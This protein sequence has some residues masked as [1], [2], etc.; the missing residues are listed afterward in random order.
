ME[1]YKF[2]L[3]IIG[4]YLASSLD[5]RMIQQYNVISFHCVYRFAIIEIKHRERG[6]YYAVCEI[7]FDD[8]K[9][10]EPFAHEIRTYNT[11]QRAEILYTA[12]TAL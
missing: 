10:M 3:P 9:V 6:I 8:K 1:D 12:L 11:K 2:L 4:R 5:I 7:F